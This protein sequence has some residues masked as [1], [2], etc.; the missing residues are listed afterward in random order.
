[1]IV[2]PLTGAVMLSFGVLLVVVKE[3]ALASEPV[4]FD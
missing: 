3:M 4:I 1:V 2:E